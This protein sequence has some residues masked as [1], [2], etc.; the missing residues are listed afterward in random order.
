MLR[1]CRHPQ[2]APPP[3]SSSSVLLLLCIFHNFESEEK[4][5]RRDRDRVHD[6]YQIEKEGH[7]GSDSC[8]KPSEKEGH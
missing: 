3:R 4:E 2:F 8:I 6:F 1:R 7:G 5:K